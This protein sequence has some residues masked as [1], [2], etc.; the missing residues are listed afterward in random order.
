LDVADVVRFNTLW[1]DIDL[2]PVEHE[3]PHYAPN[4]DGEANLR[5]L[6]I[7]SRMWNWYYKTYIPTMLMT[8]GNNVDV[9]ATYSGGQLRI[10][11]PENTSAGQIIFTDLNYDIINVSGASSSAQ[12]FVLVNEDSLI[13]VKAY[14]FATLGETLDSVFVID[15]VLDTETD[16][17]QG[18]QVRFHDQEGKEILA[19]TALLKI[20]PVPARYALG[21]NYPNPFNPTTTIHFELPE[22]AHTRIAIYDLLGR[23]IVLLENRPFNAGYHQVVWQGRD[24]YGNAIPSGMYFYRMEANGF[25]STRKMVFLK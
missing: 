23:E 13:G 18:I 24:K 19:G 14:T 5:D 10:Q 16:Y 17:N 7:F 4:L 25:S 12:H 1:P 8:S 22:D 20:I 15:M 2:A 6:S 11:L 9:S 21:Q 3:P